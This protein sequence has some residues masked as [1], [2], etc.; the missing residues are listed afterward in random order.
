MARDNFGTQILTSML[1]KCQKCI[2]I[3]KSLDAGRETQLT[4][5]GFSCPKYPGSTIPALVLALPLCE[6]R[7]VP[8]CTRG[9]IRYNVNKLHK[10]FRLLHS[11]IC[12]KNVTKLEL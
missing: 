12:P 7:H 4:F 3:F 9:E 10:I 1:R 6:N 2:E 5:G 8:G 11:A